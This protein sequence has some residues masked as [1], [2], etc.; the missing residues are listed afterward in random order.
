MALNEAKLDI[1][2]DVAVGVNPSRSGD[3]GQ[4]EDMGKT[5]ARDAQDWKNCQKR[6]EPYI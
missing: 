3:Q 5:W 6:K 1:W 2:L 4:A